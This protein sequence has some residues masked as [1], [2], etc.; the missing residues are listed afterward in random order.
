MRLYPQYGLLE[1]V[2]YFVSCSMVRQ[3]HI[4]SSFRKLGTLNNQNK[5]KYFSDR[6]SRE[7]GPFFVGDEC[8][9]RGHELTWTNENSTCITLSFCVMEN[10]IEELLKGN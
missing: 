10:N 3:L 4:P 5:L 1:F 2:D 9:A 8:D 7:L 6:S